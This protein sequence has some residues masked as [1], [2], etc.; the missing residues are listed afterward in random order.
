MIIGLVL[1][2]YKVYDGIN[3]IPLDFKNKFISYVGENGIGKSSILE[4]LDSY[5]N[6]REWNINK[7]AISQGIKTDGNEPFIMPLFLIKKDEISKKYK[8]NIEKLSNFFWEVSIKDLS[9]ALHPTFKIF[10]KEREL[11]KD[12]KEYYYLFFLGERYINLNKKVF[13]GS[14]QRTDKFEK[15]FD[16]QN[17]EED[18]DKKDNS[19]LEKEYGEVLK[20]IKVLYSYLYIP[21]ESDIKDFTKLSN[22]NMEKLFGTE[23]KKEIKGSLKDVNFQAIND[24]LSKFV[25][26]IEKTLNSD[27]YYDKGDT[28]K[29]SLTKP[30]LIE[31]ILEVYFQIRILMKKSKGSENGKTIEELSAGEKRQALINLVYAFVKKDTQ[32]EKELIIAI[33]E[34]EN[35]LHNSLCYE[36]FEKLKEISENNQ[37]LITTHWYGFLPILSKGKAHFLSIDKEKIEIESYNLYNYR[38]TIKQ[39]IVKSKN[40]IPH[41]YI[42]KSSFDLVQSI[43][44]SLR[45][46]VKYNWIICEGISEKIYFEYFFKNE[47]ENNNLKILSVGGQ[48]KVSELYEHLEIPIKSQ[49]TDLYGKVFC[50]IDTD[51]ERHKEHIGNGNKHLKIRRLYNEKIIKE[52]ELITLNNNKTIPTDIESSLNIGIFSETLEKLEVNEKYLNKNDNINECQNTSKDSFKN[53]DLPDY[54]KENNGEN[55]IIFAKKYISIMKIKNN[56]EKYM[57]NWVKEIKLFFNSSE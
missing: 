56:D 38:D 3:Y 51:S 46:Y 9:N 39:D 24:N 49:I 54:F 50:L 57:P 22:S 30:D 37:I 23:I 2:H 21:V 40:K 31:K 34:P 15:E 43:F 42:L 36:Q 48:S 19:I 45:K 6:T 4:S 7:K 55:K 35:S 20:Y 53:F 1:K 47:I 52:T 29:K 44:Y 28:G 33:D 27:Y 10:F 14:F 5:F 32:R 18:N 26:D 41:D 17:I 11:I 12:K 25:S 8:N 13:F 16:I